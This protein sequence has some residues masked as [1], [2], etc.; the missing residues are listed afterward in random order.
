M[1][2]P[3]ILYS[4]GFFEISCSE[5]LKSTPLEKLPLNVNCVFSSK[6]SSNIPDNCAIS[7]ALDSV[8]ISYG[9]SE[10]ISEGKLTVLIVVGKFSLTSIYGFVFANLY[11]PFLMARI[12]RLLFINN[13]EF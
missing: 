7:S 8:V 10:I 5:K 6:T 13:V 3:L 4:I 9:L 2:T 1:L 12:D 11:K